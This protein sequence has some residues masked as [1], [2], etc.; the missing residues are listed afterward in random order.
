LAKGKP[1]IAPSS[2]A[3][4]VTDKPTD[5]KTP[6]DQEKEVVHK[7]LKTIQDL[8]GIGPKTAAKL[9]ELGYSFVGLATAR[10]D[11]VSAEMG[12][13]VS[14]MKA[15]SWIKAAQE[16]ILAVMEPKTGKRLARER[17]LKRV[18]YKT[19]SKE[20]NR[21]TGGGFGTMRTTALAGRFSTGKTQAIYDG[22]VHCLDENNTKYCF[23][24][25]CGELHD[26]PVSVCTA[27]GKDMKRKAA[28][29]ETE[30]DCWSDE[31]VEEMA[32]AQK[33][34]IDLDDLW[35]FPC[36]NIPTAKA[37]YLQYKILQKL[38]Q[39]KKENIGFVGI[40]SMTAKFRPGY[41]R[42]EMLPVR[43]REFTEHFLLIDYLAAKHNIAWAL[44]CQVIGGVRP[45][46]VKALIMKTGDKQG[47][48][49]VGGDYLLHSISTW[50][51]LSQVRVDTYEAVVFDSNYLPRERV[52]FML[53]KSGLMDGIR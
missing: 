50:I 12:I 35:V 42:T 22:I 27:C 43:T 34:R 51:S 25:V 14:Y 33:I 38:I 48:Y 28:Y 30:P 49:P 24:G 46:A 5:A 23:C 26:K 39:K 16:S 6:G 7:T 20:F 4:M 10:A 18:F 15:V 3:A 37:Q 31:R 45:G 8:P 2:R 1:N 9:R 29:I 41:S 52:E 13:S 11:A 21:I 47:Y 36:E 40:D 53:T 19:G 32:R 17:K 44:S